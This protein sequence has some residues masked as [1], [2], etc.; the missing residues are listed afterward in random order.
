MWLTLEAKYVRPGYENLH[1]R[2]PFPHVTWSKSIFSV[3]LWMSAEANNSTLWTYVSILINEK[4]RFQRHLLLKHV[5]R[6]IYYFLQAL[7]KYASLPSINSKQWD[8]FLSFR[9]GLLYA[10]ISVHKIF[11]GMDIQQDP[12]NI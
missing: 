8:S 3:Y 9:Q 2:T 5:V 1:T 6:D 11:K 12:K 4:M 10:Y 7:H